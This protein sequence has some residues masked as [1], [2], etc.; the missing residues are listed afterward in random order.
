MVPDMVIERLLPGKTHQ[1]L[2]LG[3]RTPAVLGVL[4]VEGH[5][6]MGRAIDHEHRHH[7]HGI[8]GRVVKL[9]QILAVIEL[10]HFDARLLAKFAHYGLP[11]GFTRL[12]RARHMAP[13]ATLYPVHQQHLYLAIDFR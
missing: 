7:H 2:G 1:R 5:S 12:D 10:G 8:G 11:A 4:V 9:L 3:E 6:L 13:E